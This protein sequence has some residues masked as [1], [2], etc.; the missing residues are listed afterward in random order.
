MASCLGLEADSLQAQTVTGSHSS[1][2]SLIRS[3]AS[4]LCSLYSCVKFLCVPFETYQYWLSDASRARFPI[5]MRV[6][7]GVAED[8]CI[9]PWVLALNKHTYHKLV[10]IAFAVAE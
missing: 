3:S 1:A 6:L 2:P 8:L 7:P 9:F 10:F 4:S 5:N